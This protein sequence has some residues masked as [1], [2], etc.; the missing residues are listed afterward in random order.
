MR[1]AQALKEFGA[2]I[3]VVAPEILPE[4]SDLAGLS[5][6]ERKF[7]PEDLAGCVLAIA[8]TDSRK[9]NARIAS[10]CRRR[11]IPVNAVDDPENCDF[12]FPATLTRG[13]L[14]IGIGTS[15][16]APG[17]S[18]EMRRLLDERLPQDAG[19]RI[20]AIGRLRKKIMAEGRRPALDDEYAALVE[21]FAADLEYT[22]KTD[23]A[24][25]KKRDH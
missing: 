25:G 18:R 13:D 5:L 6:H 23:A 14:S 7:E 2:E 1:K 12:F 24:S 11:K 8:A 17:C 4:F 9:E 15:G 10:E 3:S 20:R 22:L 16:A 19:E 21:K